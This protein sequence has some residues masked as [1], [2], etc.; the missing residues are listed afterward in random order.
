LTLSLI[1]QDQKVSLLLIPDRCLIGIIKTGQLNATL[2]NSGS[3]TL[4]SIKLYAKSSH[5][6]VEIIPDKIKILQPDDKIPVQIKLNQRNF[7]EEGGFIKVI[8]RAKEFQEKLILEIDV[9]PG[10]EPKEKVLV[11]KTKF[12]QQSNTFEEMDPLSTG[13]VKIHVTKGTNLKYYIYGS[14]CAL[15]V[16]FLIWRRLRFSHKA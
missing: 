13:E 12:Q 16:G 8:A 10:T 11:V 1:S 2:K 3:I 7:D 4:N 15:I 6:D 5:F 14:L 9:Q